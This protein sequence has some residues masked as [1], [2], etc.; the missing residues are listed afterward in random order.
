MRHRAGTVTFPSAPTEVA[1]ATESR[2]NS[3]KAGSRGTINPHRLTSAKAAYRG[4]VGG[5][6]GNASKLVLGRRLPG[7]GTGIDPSSFRRPGPRMGYPADV[8]DGH[9][10]ELLANGASV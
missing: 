6:Q 1:T 8:S 3:T 2:P 7:Q 4:P 10:L 5:M 9:A